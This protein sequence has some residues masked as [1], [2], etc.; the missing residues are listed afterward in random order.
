[1]I[2]LDAAVIMEETSTPE[3]T[4]TDYLPTASSLSGRLLLLL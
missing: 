3:R 2:V 4:I 1:M